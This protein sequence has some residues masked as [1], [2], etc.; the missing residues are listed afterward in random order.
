M[1]VA[2]PADGALAGWGLTWGKQENSQ[3]GIWAP[4]G[5]GRSRQP[6]TLR[7][8]S[9]GG[10]GPCA[11]RAPCSTHCLSA[12][13]C[14]PGSERLL[15]MLQ[16]QAEPSA[17]AVLGNICCK[18][19]IEANTEIKPG[20]LKSTRD[21]QPRTLY[22]Y[23]FRS[24]TPDQRMERGV[25]RTSPLGVPQPKVHFNCNSQR[26]SSNLILFAV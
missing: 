14:S 8:S 12:V 15:F 3:L 17:G 6:Q 1:E 9:P 19:F 22:C 18:I 20:S 21:S 24:V 10:A 5:S 25:R 4:R 13:A 23:V 11:R 7:P 2:G 26:C 16:G